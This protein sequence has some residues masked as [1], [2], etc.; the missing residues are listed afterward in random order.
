MKT[1]RGEVLQKNFSAPAKSVKSELLAPAGSIEAFFAALDHGADAVYCGLKEFSAR[2]RARN[3]TLAD[4]ERMTTYAHSQKKNLYVTLNTLIKEA[5]LPKLV[6]ILAS[7]AAIPVDGLIIQDLGV[8]R[9]AR[10]HFPQLPL[11]A[12]TQMTVHNAAGVK[13]LEQMGFTRA[14]LARELSLAEITE[15]RSQTTIELEHFV[16]GALCFSISGQ[17]LF[18]SALTGTSG[19]R[20]RCAQPCRR[21]LH[22]RKQPGYHFSTSD[23]SAIELLPQLL[24]A[25]VMSF[26]IE[27]RMKS[28]EYVA[29]VVAAYR[30]M[31]DAQENQR[32]SALQEATEHLELSFGRQATKGFLTGFV[33][34]GIADSAQHGGLGRPLGDVVSLRGGMIGFTTKERLH[35][36]DRIRIQPQN[37]Q[38][39]I[40]FT[41]RE[42]FCEKKKAKVA[43]AGDFVQI[44]I[45]EKGFFRVGDAVLKVGGRPLF[46]LS[47]DACLE[48]LAKVLVAAETDTQE[49]KQLDSSVSK[50]LASL[51]PGIAPETTM[52]QEITVRGR[53][54]KDIGLLDD[55]PQVARMELP[56]NPRNIAAFQGAQHLLN[57]KKER[58]IWEIPA[59]LFGPDWIEYRHAVQMLYGLGY[60]QFRINNL[61]HIPLFAGLADVVLL[62]GFRCYT[63]NSQAALAWQD[64]GLAELTLSLEDE[65]TNISDLFHRPLTIPLA[66]TVYSPVTLLLSRIPIKG[67]RSGN[68]LHAD[69][70]EIYRIFTDTGL[71]EVMHG[72]DLS[73]LGYL[74]EIKEMGCARIIV[75]LS[76]CSTGSSKGQKILATLALDQPLPDTFT[77]NYLQGLS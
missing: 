57:P 73:L 7:L 29:R 14:V 38:A 77:F 54:L 41:V 50:A 69:N 61:G 59:M 18:S 36:G 66:L 70:D 43:K 47:P 51:L 26:K 48:R 5:E 27:G 31:L 62:G 76:Q 8:W 75:D 9:L 53:E 49:K 13:M 65:R 42:L 22:N 68:V 24:K 74:Q 46:T 34:T 2:A 10:L 63:L 16:H 35:V 28:A 30:L 1:K 21:R 17:C 20:G 25:G 15:V 6:D 12:S 33:P 60:R 71:T 45:P 3:F 40:G 72:R 52:I 37:D 19:N 32:K 23:L 11:H 39:G 56:L 67:L 4:V 55:S 64:L 58:L 44:K